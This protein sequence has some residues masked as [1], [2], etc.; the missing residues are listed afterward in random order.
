MSNDQT[1]NNTYPEEGID[2]LID[3]MARQ[4]VDRH[5]VPHTEQIQPSG[6]QVSNQPLPNQSVRR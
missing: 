6:Q 4:A 5:L 3:I 2:A 1:K